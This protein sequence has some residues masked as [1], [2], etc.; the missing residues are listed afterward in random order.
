MSIV[1]RDELL[2]VLYRL[3][4]WWTGR[5]ENPPAFRRLAF[6]ECRN[7]LKASA[8]RRAVLLSGP[9]RVGKS[10]ILRQLALDECALPGADARG[11]LYLD[12]GLPQFKVHALDQLLDV[13]HSSVHPEGTP[14]LLLLDEVHY[15]QDWDR[16]LKALIDH[17]PEYRVLATG[18]ASLR[19]RDKLVDSGVGRWLTVRIPT[20]SFYEFLA[21]RGD[22]IADSLLNGSLP[23]LFHANDG[24]R[25]GLAASARPLAPLFERY[26]LTGGF[27]ETALLSDLSYIQ[28]ILREDVVERV[29]KRDMT[30]LFDVRSVADLERLFIYLCYHL[31]GQLNITTCASEL[32]VQRTT[33]QNHLNI[34]EQAHLVYKLSPEYAGGKK[35]LKARHKYYLADAAL[36]NAVLLRNEDVLRDPTELGHIVETTVIRHFVSFYHTDSPSLAFWRDPST[37]VEVDLLIRRPDQTIAVEVKYREGAR[38]RDC[39]GLMK[40]CEQRPPARAYLV[41]REDADFGCERVGASDTP[42][43]TIP[44]HILCLLLGL[45]ERR[46]WV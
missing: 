41:S 24:E 10:V 29:L 43:L 21:I 12:L 46:L 40:L 13:Y 42:V 23:K 30:T 39:P 20:L 19:Q 34:L 5:S 38:P 17:R 11:V 32:G 31:G 45:V 35:V 1:H 25:A 8:P 18:S 33:V 26:L 7:A 14:T 4:P 37:D 36:R 9:R 15:A 16:H 44:A 28:R 6:F 3:N 22:V 27:P 2:R